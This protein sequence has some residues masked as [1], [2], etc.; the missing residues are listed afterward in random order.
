MRDE[1]G[2]QSISFATGGFDHIIRMWQPSTGR[3]IKGFD[4]NDSQVCQVF[5]I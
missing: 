3:Y 1:T 2:D 5:R 4:H